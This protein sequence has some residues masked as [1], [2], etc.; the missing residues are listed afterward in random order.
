MTS[1]RLYGDTG[2][3]KVFAVPKGRRRSY[4]FSQ[5]AAFECNSWRR[6]YIF[7]SPSY[8]ALIRVIVANHN[9]GLRWTVCGQAFEQPG[10]PP[11]TRNVAKFSAFCDQI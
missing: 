7:R 10:L 9:Y 8:I 11:F 2:L 4:R 1:I 6:V 5:N 3:I